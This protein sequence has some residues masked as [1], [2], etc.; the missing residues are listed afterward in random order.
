MPASTPYENY[1]YRKRYESVCSENTVV[2]RKTYPSV[3]I[4][5]GAWKLLNDH[6]R[7]RQI[8]SFLCVLKNFSIKHQKNF[9]RN[10]LVKLVYRF[11][12]NLVF[13]Y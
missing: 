3:R 4:G 10:S 2:R 5:T 9:I 6:Q 13:D 12:Q 11:S 1:M 8:T 7:R